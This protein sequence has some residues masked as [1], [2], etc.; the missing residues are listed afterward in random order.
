MKINLALAD[1]EHTKQKHHTSAILTS[2]ACPSVTQGEC[3]VKGEELFFSSADANSRA[4]GACG[5]M[6]AAPRPVSLHRHEPHTHPSRPVVSALFELGA[7]KREIAGSTTAGR[8]P[9]SPPPI[10]LPGVSAVNAEPVPAPHWEGSL[11]TQWALRQST[12]N[13]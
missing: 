12:R 6:N 11:V 3:G 9:H 1:R 10:S 5:K 8:A 4:G 13:A 2:T 7:E